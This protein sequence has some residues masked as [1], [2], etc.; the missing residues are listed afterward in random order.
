MSDLKRVQDT[1]VPKGVRL[2]WLARRLGLS[3][4]MLYKLAASGELPAYKCGR[5][6]LVMESDVLAYL[7]SKRLSIQG[8]Q[9]R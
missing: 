3:K 8:E 1:T 4:A 6:L 5:S 2:P 7:Q 9:E